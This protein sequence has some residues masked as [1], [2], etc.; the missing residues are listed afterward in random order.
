MAARLPLGDPVGRPQRVALGYGLLFGETASS[1][2]A[3]SPGTGKQVWIRK[4]TSNPGEG[5]DMTPQLYDGR[6]IVSTMPGNGIP[7]Y[8]PGAYGVVYAL[9]ARTGKELWSFSTV[10]AAQSSGATRRSTAGEDASTPAGAD[11]VAARA[12]RAG[13][14]RR[15]HSFDGGALPQ[16]GG[17]V[18]T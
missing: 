2:F 5:I 16:V 17:P 8:L 9:D 4:L 12:R 14:A 15:I 11:D 3:L 1:V 18:G 7:F 10:K 6:L 13:R